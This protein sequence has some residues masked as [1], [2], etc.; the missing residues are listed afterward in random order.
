MSGTFLVRSWIRG[1]R[2]AGIAGGRF[3]GI[4]GGR[5]AGIVGGRFAGIAGGQFVRVG[6]VPFCWFVQL[7]AVFDSLCFVKASL[8]AKRPFCSF[9]WFF[10]LAGSI[11]LSG[12]SFLTF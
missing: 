9:C 8:W 12:A 2:L 11:V 5:L 6:A 1:G 7:G 4:A 10:T 3:A